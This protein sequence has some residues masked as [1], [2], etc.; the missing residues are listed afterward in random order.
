MEDDAR[1][2]L[3]AISFKSSKF[4][5][6]YCIRLSLERSRSEPDRGRF[7]ELFWVGTLIFFRSTEGSGS[8]SGIPTRTVD[9]L[10]VGRLE[11]VAD[12]NRFDIAPLLE[13]A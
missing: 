1:L 5:S 11:A 4:A 10:I 12:D 3:A 13:K 8:G 6:R 2:T 7:A 9:I